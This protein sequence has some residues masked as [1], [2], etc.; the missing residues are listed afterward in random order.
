MSAQMDNL[1]KSFGDLSLVQT[2]EMLVERTIKPALAVQNKIERILPTDPYFARAE[3]LRAK[4]NLSKMGFQNFQKLLCG[5]RTFPCIL[6]QNPIH[7]HLEYKEMVAETKTLLWLEAQLQRLEI[8][9]EDIIIVD[10]FPMLT[11]K[12]VKSH[13]Y[14]RKQA[15]DEMFALTLDFI[16]TF[17][18]PVIL[19]C[20]FVDF[21]GA[22]VW[23]S[24]KHEAAEKLR[25]SMRGAK[26]Q[27]VSE[28]S[29]K[30]HTTHIVHGFHPSAILRMPP[31]IPGQVERLKREDLLGGIISSLFQPYSAWRNNNNYM[32]RK[33]QSIKKRAI[34]QL[35]E[36]LRQTKNEL[37]Q[38]HE[39]GLVMGISQEPDIS[40]TL[41]AWK[42]FDIALD[43]MS[44][45]LSL[46]K[47]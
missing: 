42:D 34:K 10:L 9:L 47:N 39:E 12:W 40:P 43:V 1:S 11:D 21:Q 13:P 46:T 22:N 37:D 6:L 25:S 30:D 27:R 26:N 15:I 31:T 44:K 18:P 33:R 16:Y 35:I 36:H 28:F 2:L 38:I 29:H 20:Q 23:A 32:L 5:V 24:L 17:N 14:E 41:A 7:D 19:S 4:Y 3:K 45:Q 8:K